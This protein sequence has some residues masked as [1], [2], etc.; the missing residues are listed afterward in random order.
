MAETPSTMLELGTQAPG[1]EL[2]NQNTRLDRPVINLDEYAQQAV[3]ICFICNHCPYVVLIASKLAEL[4]AKW[5]KSGVNLVAISSNDV[6]RFPAD[7]PEKM[8]EFAQQY[9]FGFP[10]L[11]DESQQVARAYRAACT[12]DIFLFDSAHQLVYRGQFDSARPGNGQ[13][14]TGQDLDRAVN[15]LISGQ[16][17]D[18]SQTPSVGCSIKWKIG[19][20]PEYS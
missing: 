17:I 14:V 8:T 4:A 10:Y 13:P 2:P 19:N 9:G 3:I 18:E 6:D 20:E 15:S 1:F 5:Q 16:A 12:P 11:Y 7:G